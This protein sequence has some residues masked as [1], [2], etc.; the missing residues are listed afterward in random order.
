VL[1]GENFGRRHQRR[2]PPGLDDRRAPNP[3]QGH[4][5]AFDGRARMGCMAYGVDI[6]EKLDF[7]PRS[8]FL[9][10]QAGIKKKAL[11]GRQ[12]G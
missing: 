1:A 6:V 2:L 11:R 3:C 8:Q 10:Q 12:K 7:L 9:R 5:G 4:A